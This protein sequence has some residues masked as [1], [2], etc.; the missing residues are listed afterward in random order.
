LLAVA[1]DVDVVQSEVSQLLH[2]PVGEHDP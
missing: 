1:F 2:G